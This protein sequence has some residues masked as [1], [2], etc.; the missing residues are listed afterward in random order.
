MRR[1]HGL[2]CDRRCLSLAGRRPA[3]QAGLAGVPAAFHHQ[4]TLR[5]RQPLVLPHGGVPVAAA[6]TSEIPRESSGN[7]TCAP[8]WASFLTKRATAKCCPCGDLLVV[9]TSNGINEGPHPRALATG[10]SLIAVDKRSAEVVWQAIGAGENVLHGQ[11]CS[12][13]AAT[14]NGRTQVLFG[15]GDGWLRAYDAESGRELWR[16]DGNPKDALWRPRPGRFL[17]LPD[18]GF[19]GLRRRRPGSSSPWAK[20]RRMG[21]ARRCCMPSAPL[22]KGTSRD[23]RRLWTCRQMGRVVATPVVSDGLVYVADLGGTVYCVD[24]KTGDVLWKHDTRRRRLGMPAPGWPATVCRQRR[25][26]DDRPSCRTCR[27]TSWRKSRWTSR[28]IPAQQSSAMQCTW[29]APPPVSD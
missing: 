13:T 15:G 1:P 4:R 25:G 5:G 9:C 26:H 29:P 10:A 22:A 7:S 8:A 11:W 16:F 3:R 18:R 28:C 20:T 14:V 2:S 21:T 6:S 23:T 17:P 19:T 12:P 24:A 27:R